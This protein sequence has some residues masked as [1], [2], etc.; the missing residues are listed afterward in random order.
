M[1]KMYIK[2]PIRFRI[3]LSAVLKIHHNLGFYVAELAIRLGSPWSPMH[4][5][6]SLYTVIFISVGE[7]ERRL[8]DNNLTAASMY[9]NTSG[10]ITDE[11]YRRPGANFDPDRASRYAIAVSPY[12]CV[13]NVYAYRGIVIHIGCSRTASLQ[14]VTQA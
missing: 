13:C 4:Y 14:E 9:R 12:V 5:R 2:C 11:S 1:C 7:L 8:S 3:K 6:R 10:L